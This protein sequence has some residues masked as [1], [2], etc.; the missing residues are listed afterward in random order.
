MFRI[1]ESLEVFMAH[2]PVIPND[3]HTAHLFR[4]FSFLDLNS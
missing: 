4:Q 3:I 2:L 1:V